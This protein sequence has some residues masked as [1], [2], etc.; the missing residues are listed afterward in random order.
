MKNILVVSMMLMSF[1]FA[2]A[3]KVKGNRD[4]TT[5]IITVEPFQTIS[6]GQ[7]LKVML[8][9]GTTPKVDILADSNLHRYI[10]VS[11]INGVLT[12]KTTAD[13]RRNKELK[14]DIIYTPILTSINAFEDAQISTLTDLRLE[15]L[16][17]NVKDDAKVFMTGRV[18]NLVFNAMSGSKSECNLAGA[19]AQVNLNG[20]S[21]TKALIKYDTVDIMMTDRAEARIEGDANSATMVLEGKSNL[22]SEKL[23]LKD[24]KLNITRDAATSINVSKNI[25]LRASGDAKVELYNNPKI[26]MVDFSGKA[27]LMKK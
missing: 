16:Q 8:S 10:D 24:L 15:N 19:N 22:T 11:V 26:N 12:I 21:S 1:A 18:D 7:D 3:Q 23:D 25:E 14:I 6:I 9:E 5:Q 20:K 13:I 4:V 17:I 27:V 2:K